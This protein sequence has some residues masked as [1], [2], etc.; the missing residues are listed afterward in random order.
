LRVDASNGGPRR[1]SLDRPPLTLIFGPSLE[2]RSLVQDSQNATHTV[3]DPK[4]TFDFI[5]R[6]YS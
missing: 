4:P 2:R 6:L 5:W 3:G 1:I